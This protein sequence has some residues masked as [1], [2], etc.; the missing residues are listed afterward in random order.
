MDN[1]HHMQLSE[2][3]PMEHYVYCYSNY[4][5]H[6]HT[7]THAN[8]WKKIGYIFTKMHTVAISECSNYGYF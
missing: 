2:N 4:L 7:Y 3:Q 6:T 5:K 1:V 8:T